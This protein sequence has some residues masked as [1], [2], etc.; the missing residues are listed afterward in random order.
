MDI[1]TNFRTEFHNEVT[2]YPRIQKKLLYRSRHSNIYLIS[3]KPKKEPG[4]NYKIIM[5]AQNKKFKQNTQH[6]FKIGHI[7]INKIKSSSFCLTYD[8]ISDRRKEYLLIEYI[9]G[10]TLCDYLRDKKLSKSEND[11]YEFV[12]ILLKI[13]DVLNIVQ[14]KYYFTHYDLH[15]SNVILRQTVDDED[16]EDDNRY[17][18]SY[19]VHESIYIKKKEKTN[20]Y[21]SPVFIDFEY[22]TAKRCSSS[23]SPCFNSKV[24]PQFGYIGVFCSGI[25]LLRLLF[26]LKRETMTSSVK[27]NTLYYRI[28]NLINNIFT[29]CYNIHNP[30]LF[31]TE[32]LRLH[33]QLYYY[34]LHTSH[35]F[36]TPLPIMRYIVNRYKSEL[37]LQMQR[38][39]R[40][41]RQQHRLHQQLQ[42]ERQSNMKIEEYKNIIKEIH[43][44]NIY[45][46]SLF[47]SREAHL[48]FLRQ[49][50]DI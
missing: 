31:T 42:Q 27:K 7:I 46:P 9:E 19:T 34:M 22:S 28:N 50:K 25:D 45:I 4:L 5:K 11:Y 36:K 14:E 33:G 23:Y 41:R 39:G 24:F 30:D 10:I 21:L 16:N 20:T 44:N 26:C 18:C 17:L 3:L 35:I 8:N 32:Q 15:L 40:R 6:S 29:D 13:L 12:C 37:G 1:Y 38:Q 49:Y 48:L 43:K 2:E 47:S